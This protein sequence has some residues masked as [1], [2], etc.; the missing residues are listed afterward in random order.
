M[1]FWREVG[2]RL[3]RNH[4]ESGH[5]A[6]LVDQDRFAQPELWE[7][8][9]RLLEADSAGPPTFLHGDVHAGNVYHHTG[10]RGGLLD[11]QL[12]LR[13]CWALDVGYLLTSTLATGDRRDHERDL[14]AGYLDRLRAAGVD[15]P[16]ADVAWLAYRQNALYGLLM[17][18]LTPDG[19]HTDAA[20]AEYVRRCLAAVEDLETVPALL[21]R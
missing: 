18:L 19:V 14:L 12:S 15:A 10:A 8:F 17:W 9:D 6:A 11:W 16:E 7:A 3:T 13:G 1:R 4:L 20:Q 5:R 2:P 21:G